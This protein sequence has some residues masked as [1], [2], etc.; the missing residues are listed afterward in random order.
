M[1]ATSSVICTKVR[2]NNALVGYLNGTVILWDWT[3][4]S[5]KLELVPHGL[6]GILASSVDFTDQWIYVA[7]GNE[8][9]VYDQ[10]TKDL[11]GVGT[12]GLQSDII[13]TAFSIRNQELYC[14]TEDGGVYFWNMS[15][16]SGSST[17][18]RFD[19]SNTHTDGIRCL[20][21]RGQ[22]I[23]TGSYDHVNVVIN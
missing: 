2:E 15:D 8:I 9:S 17:M 22:L 3:T 10:K 16:I 7:I 20:A 13:I 5:R 23:I 1:A 21:M 4:G 12:A 19:T 6:G 14:C 18:E 11:V